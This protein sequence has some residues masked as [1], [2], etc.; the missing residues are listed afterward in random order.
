VKAIEAI[1]MSMEER[2]SAFCTLFDQYLNEPKV[3]SLL[4]GRVT[5]TTSILS[6]KSLKNLL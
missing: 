1:F 5:R 4:E 2:K 6:M 3:W